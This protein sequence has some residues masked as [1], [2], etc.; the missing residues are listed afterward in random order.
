MSQWQL[1]TFQ[2]I[3]FCLSLI[4][5]LYSVFLSLRFS[6]V[7]WD[8]ESYKITKLF[9]VQF[10]PFFTTFTCLHKCYHPILVDNFWQ[11][12]EFHWTW[13]LRQYRSDNICWF[14]FSLICFILCPYIERC[15]LETP[16]LSL[17]F[18]LSCFK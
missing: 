18:L 2:S 9:S 12:S 7:F 3:L 5:E 8:D 17:V 15:H 16:S 6:C 14:H 13:V 10:W 4:T 1:V 11:V